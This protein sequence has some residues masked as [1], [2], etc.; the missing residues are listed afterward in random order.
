MRWVAAGPAADLPP[1]APVA[2]TADQ[3]PTYG[4]G[5]ADINKLVRYPQTAIENK[6]EGIVYASFM[7]DE[8]GRVEAPS[9]VRGIGGGCDEEVLRVLRQT[10][11]IGRRP[12]AAG[13]W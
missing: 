8:Q 1:P 5:P 6:T 12:G 3:M 2:N 9:I 10:S 11:G 4:N 7:V 13:S